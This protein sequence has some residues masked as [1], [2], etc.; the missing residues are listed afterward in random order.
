MAGMAV[1]LVTE[2][3]DRLADAGRPG[4]VPGRCKYDVRCYSGSGAAAA[5]AIGA[6]W[7]LCEDIG[8]L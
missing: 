6:P 4:S 3:K 1:R 8:L 7:V 2:G 5:A